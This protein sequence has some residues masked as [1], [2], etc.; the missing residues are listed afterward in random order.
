MKAIYVPKAQEPN[1]VNDVH[2]CDV[3]KN[4]NISI[5][6]KACLLPYNSMTVFEPF[7]HN[8]Y[9]SLSSDL[10]VP[11]QILRDTGASQSLVLTSVLAFS[12]DSYTGS[13]V[14]I[15]GISSTDY[16]PVPLHK[17]YLNSELVSGPVTI[18][19]TSTLPYD[20]IQLL[21]GNDL[22]GSK[23]SIDPI[24][25][26]NPCLDQVE[27][28]IQK[29]IPDIYPACAVTRSMSKKLDETDVDLSDTLV[30]QMFHQEEDSSYI[31][32]GA[33][34]LPDVGKDKETVLQPMDKTTDVQLVDSQKRDPSINRLFQDVV[35][36]KEIDNIP[37]CYFLKHDVLMRKYRPPDLSVDD[38][39]GVLYQVVVP[40]P[41]RQEILRL[42]HETPL[43]GHLGKNKTA[44]KI[45]QHFYW[46]GVWNDVSNFCKT[47]HTCQVVGK[48]N[49][50]IPKAP[51]HPIPAF[52]EPFS[53]VL[54][55]CV[56]PLPKTRA[57]NQY[58]LTIMCTSTRFPEAVPLRNIKAK[59]IV[60]ALIKFFTLVGLPRSIQSDQGSNFMSGLFQQIMHE[61]QITQYKSTAYHPESQGAIERFHQTLKNMIRTN[62]FD[63]NKD[64]DEGIP[65]LL[66]AVRESVQESLGFSPFELV[67][68]HQ[69]RGPLRLL[70]EKF[71]SD[72]N[73]ELNLLQYVSDFRSRLHSASEFAKQNLRTSQGTMKL[74]YDRKSSN[75][76]FEPGQKVLV[77][78]PVSTSPLQAR[79]FGP[80]TIDKKIS[81]VNYVLI[82]PDRRKG[83][84]LCHINMLKPYFERKMRECDVGN[85]VG[86]VDV[87]ARLDAPNTYSS[88]SD[89]SESNL[90]VDC[91]K[92]NNSDILDDIDSKL[93]HLSA[94]QR[95]DVR[96]LILEYK[97]LFPDVPSQTDKTYHDVIIE[98][99]VT[100]IKQ[101]AYRLNP[102]KAKILKNEVQYL[103]DNKLAEPSVNCAWSSPCILVP[104]AK[105]GTYRMCTDYRKVN[106][107]TKTDT[108]PI[109][110]VDDC[111]DKLGNAVFVSK[112]DLLKGY[113]QV[114]LTDRAKEVSTFVTPFG[115]YSYCVMPFGMKNSAATF[116]R[117]VNSVIHNLEN[118][119][120][121]IDDV[122]VY[123]IHWTE[124]LDSIRKLF[125][126]VRDAK[127][128][129][130]LEK[131]DFTCAT[132][133]YLGHVVGQGQIKPVNAKVDI[134]VNFPQPGAKKELMR[135]LGMI[136]FYRKFCH[137][138]ATVSNPLTNLLKKKAKFIWTDECQQAF[139][140]LKAMLKSSPILLA[141]D[142]EKPFKL[143]IDASEV[144]VGS[145]LLQEDSCGVDHPVAYFSK[146]LTS[147][148]KNYSTIEKECLSLILA[149]NHFEVYVSM[150]GQQLT[151]YTDHNPLTFLD[152]LKNKNQRLIRW[153]LELQQYNLKIIHIRGKDNVL[154]DCLSR[155]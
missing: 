10:S 37:A 82:T 119:E 27:D 139:E 125:D 16:T 113:W 47:C 19:V 2:R 67:F 65:L 92:L 132:V 44:N 111:I 129:I 63:T 83:K 9:I 103:L 146:K 88:F 57:G 51:L 95:N 106:C 54:I 22:A 123:N 118:T 69:I 73:S 140:K 149:I 136:G 58:L 78:L 1:L 13:D 148:Q 60:K 93:S 108:Y 43:A 107:V 152:R 28:P 34:E 53:R 14:L 72:E 66:F 50:V 39:Y 144:A 4:G 40:E 11:I 86:S 81:D 127:L 90:F 20:G 137:N 12:S 36:D 41:Y 74:R 6:E 42:A 98:E 49:Q 117:L 141:P 31:K 105:P 30:G 110:R 97:D 134:I 151:V 120:A 21:L 18:G 25:C 52:G 91:V 70:K 147:A 26:K 71:I 128:S 17:V 55:D 135:F 29:E 24:V 32:P 77:F 56:G 48:P 121:Y 61:L 131:C 115:N 35:Q 68:G 23:V 130:N 150:G 85:A 143:A 101:H 104:K 62:C 133:V 45:L 142:F 76:V 154:A 102:E 116:Q 99:K 109:P 33:H 64:W 38:D 122:I 138:F 124:H 89:K 126:R 153:S 8:G 112:F 114:P 155:I 15:K 96:N 7:I 5:N 100:P 46:P 145:V 75:R 80:Y 94:Q 84:Q 79:F 59:T 87:V 3:N